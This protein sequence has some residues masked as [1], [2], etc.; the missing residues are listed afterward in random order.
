MALLVSWKLL[1]LGHVAPRLLPRN[2]PPSTS[3]RTS[4]RANSFEA[5]QGLL[6]LLPPNVI[7]VEIL[8]TKG[9]DSR[10]L[11]GSRNPGEAYRQQS[12]NSGLDA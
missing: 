4:E 8:G 6:K 5:A 1:W 2:R 12:S 3:E 11:E 7:S 10:N 9:H